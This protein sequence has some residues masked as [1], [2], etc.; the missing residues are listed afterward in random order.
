MAEKL[1]NY[2]L[3]SCVFL[4]AMVPDVLGAP[5]SKTLADAQRGIRSFVTFSP[6]N[7]YL[8]II[9]LIGVLLVIATFYFPRFGLFVMLFFIMI[10][11]DLPVGRG[12]TER[13][14]TIRYE[15][16]IL[17]LVS[18]GWIFNR[19]KTR[20]LSNLKDCHLYKP[21]LAMTA[22][23][24]IATLTGYFQ[25]TVHLNTGFLYTMKRLEYFWI[26]FMTY[27]LMETENEAWISINIFLLVAAIVAVIGIG[28]FT[29][30]PMSDLARGGS[31]ATA[32]L[33]RAN[34][35]ADFYLIILGV[36]LGLYIHCR[37]KYWMSAYLGLIGLFMFAIIMTKS[38]GA[39]IAIPFIIL[40]IILVSKS[41]KTVVFL[42]AIFILFIAYSL[43]SMI[44]TDQNAE[45]L[46]HKHNDD[47]KE[48]FTS[49]GEVMEKGPKADSSFN[50]RYV[51]WINTFPE[52]MKYPILGHGVGSIPLYFFDNQYVTEL[53]NTGFVGLAIFLYLNL[54]IFIAVLNLYL[55]TKEDFY[56][57]L[58]LGFMG[59]HAGIMVHGITITNFYT[60]INMEAFWFILAILMLIF[61]LQMKKRQDA[62]AVTTISH[63]VS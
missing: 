27:N 44:I 63:N 15:D 18:I 52:I 34:T 50:A 60:I 30:A 36:A 1:K 43:G 2:I 39:Y 26:F 5:Y 8:P 57:G 55:F 35:L 14:T 19:A 13:A 11:T 24:I 10:S 37:N 49:I 53:F 23:I 20:T 33:G 46:M 31:T 48:Q 3:L 41:K 62:P 56:K 9:M 61:H 7:P 42:A 21:I 38:R 58:A 29:L 12:N 47:I 45:L 59:G 28:Q 6:D 40:M 17:L 32:G 51:S 22:V 16:V 54:A 4:C 25:E